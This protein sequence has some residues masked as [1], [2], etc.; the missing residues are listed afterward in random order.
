MTLVRLALPACPVSVV[1]EFHPVDPRIEEYWLMIEDMNWGPVCFL[2]DPQM[3]SVTIAI[4]CWFACLFFSLEN[5][6]IDWKFFF[7]YLNFHSS[8]YLSQMVWGGRED[9]LRDES[10]SSPIMRGKYSAWK[11]DSSRVP[12]HKTVSF[13]SSDLL[14]TCA[15]LFRDISKLICS[16]I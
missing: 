2:C 11:A 9:W 16:E 12:H 8:A 4:T 7:I 13:P 15:D 14:V 10:K 5:K 1:W 3:E 6:W